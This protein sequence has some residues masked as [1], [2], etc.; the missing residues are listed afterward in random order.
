MTPAMHSRN[1]R[2]NP[3]IVMRSSIDRMEQRTYIPRRSRLKEAVMSTLFTI[4]LQG[5]IAGRKDSLPTH[6]RVLPEGMAE[7]MTSDV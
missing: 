7:G 3:G 4:A 2:F 1:T 6:G 5:A